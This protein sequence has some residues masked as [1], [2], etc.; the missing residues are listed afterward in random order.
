MCRFN[1]ATTNSSLS[2]DRLAD[3]IPLLNQS[4]I[5]FRVYT[6]EITSLKYDG[7]Y[8]VAKQI[9][10]DHTDEPYVIFAEDDLVLTEFFS[11]EKLNTSINQAAELNLD[12]LAT[13][14]WL[15]YEEIAVADGLLKIGGFR[16]TQLTVIF[17][18]A[19]QI[20]LDSPVYNHFEDT[21]SKC[22]PKLQIGLTFPFLSKQR[23]DIPSMIVAENHNYLFHENEEKIS[24]QL[25]KQAK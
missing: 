8:N 1:I 18:P 11:M 16:G 19:Y 17:R 3:L 9:I 6:G 14:A 20:L 23:E 7:L 22:Q 21:I 15:S 12:I 10:R 2:A 25:N 5:P 4:V 24:K 13:G